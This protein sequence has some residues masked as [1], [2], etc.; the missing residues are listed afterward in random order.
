MKY[1]YTSLLTIVLSLIISYKSEALSC[2]ESVSENLTLSESFYCATDAAA[3]FIIVDRVTVNLNGF[4]I[5]GDERGK[6]I[7]I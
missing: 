1:K 6:G 4:S 7:Q 5:Q 2:G 3:L